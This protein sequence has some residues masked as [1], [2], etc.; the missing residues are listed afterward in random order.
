MKKSVFC[1]FVVTF[2]LIG[3]IDSVRA[4]EKVNCIIVQTNDGAEHAI[5]LSTVSRQYIEANNWV[6]ELKGSEQKLSYPLEKLLPF[7]IELRS[8]TGIRSVEAEKG[9]T[10]YDE[11]SNLAISV[12][13]GIVG[14]YSIYDIYGRLLQKGYESGDKATASVPSGGMY[15]VKVNRG[16]KKIV[17]K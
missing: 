8:L 14:D 16:V 6:F 12:S 11:G 1:F 4:Q 5:R 3:S 10:V 9:W 17:K 15:I 2:L 7:K 13:D